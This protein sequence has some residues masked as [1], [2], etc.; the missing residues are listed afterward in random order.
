MTI[1]ITAT[2]YSLLNLC[3]RNFEG[4]T[5]LPTRVL[6]LVTYLGITA[7]LA[8]WVGPWALVWVLG[9]F[10]IGSVFH[11]IWC[12]RNGIN[13]LTAEPK[14]RYYKLRGWL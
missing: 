8:V 12:S 9:L 4:E 14:E 6:K 3:F 11:F 13:P 10:A 1:A 7:L 5:P 2:L